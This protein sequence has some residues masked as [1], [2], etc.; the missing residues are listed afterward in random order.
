MVILFLF[1]SCS[2]TTQTTTWEDPRKKLSAG[3]LSNSSGVT[4]SSPSTSPASSL[5]NLQN[6][7][8]NL[9]DGWEQ[10]KTAEGEV[11]FINHKTRTTSWYD[12]RIRK[13]EFFMHLNSLTV[14][15]LQIFS[16][17]LFTPYKT[18]VMCNKYS[19]L[20]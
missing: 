14:F 12:P 15:D 17:F 7:L 3:S 6:N 13:F 20:V 10:A 19:D 1:F 16:P 2:H 8:G 4:C 18:T 5:I 9:P 11:Y